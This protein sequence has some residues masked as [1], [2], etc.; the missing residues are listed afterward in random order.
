LEQAMRLHRGNPLYRRS[1]SSRTA[2]R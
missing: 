2:L 1:S